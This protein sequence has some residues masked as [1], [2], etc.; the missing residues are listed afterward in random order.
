M[1]NRHRPRREVGLSALARGIEGVES[2]LITE[3][4]GVV[5]E[6]VEAP[7]RVVTRDAGDRQFGQRFAI[8]LL[9]R[10]HHRNAKTAHGVDKVRAVVV[11]VSVTCRAIPAGREN[12]DAGLA[13]AYLA[14]QLEPA[15]ISRNQ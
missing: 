13:L 9:E 4:A 7:A 12:A 3:L 2:N 15:P 14:A 5:A 1:S 10:E 11:V 8:G 6:R